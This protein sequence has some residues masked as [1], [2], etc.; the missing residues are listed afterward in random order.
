[1]VKHR[2]DRNAVL[3]GLTALSEEQAVLDER[4]LDRVDDRAQV[5]IARDLPALLERWVLS[6]L[7]GYRMDRATHAASGEGRGRTG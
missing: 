6:A 4:R 2:L 5:R 7:V 1:M 3:G